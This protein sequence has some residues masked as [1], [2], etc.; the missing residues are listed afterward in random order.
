MATSIG[1][2]KLVRKTE[3]KEERKKK[4]QNGRKTDS[5]AVKK[6]GKKKKEGSKT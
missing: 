3:R 1:I 5:T 2:E 6:W 4:R